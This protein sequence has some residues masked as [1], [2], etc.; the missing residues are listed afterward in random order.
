MTGTLHACH[1]K[2]AQTYRGQTLAAR[3]FETALK[4]SFLVAGIS[5]HQR[6]SIHESPSI[7]K[8]PL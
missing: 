7:Y 8:S 6:S 4:N 2:Q 5:M 3:I 1:P